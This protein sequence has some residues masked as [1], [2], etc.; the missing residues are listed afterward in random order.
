MQIT[1]IYIHGFR[2][3]AASTKPKKIAKLLPDYKI[4]AP[5]FS[6]NPTE[7][8]E[9]LRQ[10]LQS[11]TGS[12]YLMGTSLGGFYAMYA[13]LQT[14]LKAFCINPS[15]RSH[16]T[17]KDEVGEYKTY[18]LELDYHF[19]AAYIQQLEQMHSQLWEALSTSSFK[20]SL[21]VYFNEDDDVIP[22]SLFEKYK[23]YFPVIYYPKGGHRATNINAIIQD[24]QPHLNYNHYGDEEGYIYLPL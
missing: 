4:I 10:L 24:L 17:L 21:H 5:S 19:K 1:I 20:S 12:T 15:L 13:A 8:I 6:P 3:D 7:V 11:T 23:P 18:N 14:G 16:E 2:S 9:Q 22:H